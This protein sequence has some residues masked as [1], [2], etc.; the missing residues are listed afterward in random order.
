MKLIKQFLLNE[1]K[2][3]FYTEDEIKQINDVELKQIVSLGLSYKISKIEMDW[4]NALFKI[5]NIEIDIKNTVRG[6]KDGVI[7][8]ID[9]VWVES[10]FK[11]NMDIINNLSKDSGLYK[12]IT[13]ILNN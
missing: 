1:S 13:T 4:L 7:I 8:F 11:N 2:S 10:A 9:P 3:N 6:T 12:I 5:P